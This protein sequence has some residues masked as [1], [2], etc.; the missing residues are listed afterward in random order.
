MI[1]KFRTLTELRNFCQNRKIRIPF[2]GNPFTDAPWEEALAEHIE[3]YGSP[4]GEGR[5]LDFDCEGKEFR[6]P[7]YYEDGVI[8]V[9]ALVSL[10]D[11]KWNVLGRDRESGNSVE[12]LVPDGALIYECF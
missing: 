10:P 7:D 1:P 5:Y 8:R 11:G 6:I 3:R 9:I 12:L 2:D 4:G